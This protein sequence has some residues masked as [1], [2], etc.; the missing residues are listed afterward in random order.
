[1][2]A[3]GSKQS[4]KSGSTFVHDHLCMYNTK[5][6]DVGWPYSSYCQLCCSTAALACRMIKITDGPEYISRVGDILFQDDTQ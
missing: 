3:G 2:I 1:M 4:F 5:S 6:Q